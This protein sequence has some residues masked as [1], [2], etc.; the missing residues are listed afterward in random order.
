[1]NHSQLV[2][3]LRRLDGGGKGIRTF[4]WESLSQP[5]QV[6]YKRNAAWIV[7]SN[8]AQNAAVS[9]AAD[10]WGQLVRPDG[11]R[12]MVSLPAMTNGVQ[13][14]RINGLSNP[15][16]ATGVAG[17]SVTGGQSSPDGT[18]NAVKWICPSGVNGF[19]A[20]EATP[21]ASPAPNTHQIWART[22]DGS[23][24]ANWNLEIQLPYKRFALTA[25]AA[26]KPF[27]ANI[28]RVGMGNPTYLVPV[29]GDGT[30]NAG[31]GWPVGPRNITIDLYTFIRAWALTDVLPY[32]PTS[33]PLTGTSHRV[34]KYDC[35]DSAGYFAIALGETPVLSAAA[36]IAVDCDLL[37]FDASNYVRFR[38]A[39]DKRI[40]LVLNGVTV[41]TTAVQAFAG[42]AD[43]KPVLWNSPSGCGMTIGG[44]TVTGAAQAPMNFSALPAAVRVLGAYDDTKQFPSYLAGE[45][46][47]SL[48]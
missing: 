33:T 9:I 38:G 44:V 10:T 3:I 32:F 46:R 37:S 48:S 2:A 30:P 7:P 27:A 39:S 15:W 47:A 12:V 24:S 22:G 5:G 21:S 45:F 23:A 19:P 41:L 40:A 43:L 17:S 31:G 34:W 26:W 42:N 36:D 14:D 20:Y 29:S 25:V 6:Q 35:V 4:S 18:T 16:L 13:G 8:A 1:V 11:K 28:D